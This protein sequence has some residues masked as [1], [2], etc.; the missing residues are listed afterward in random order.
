MIIEN[1]EVYYK[2][3]GVT[4]RYHKGN[5][6]GIS[7]W[8]SPVSS[9]EV[10]EAILLVNHSIELFGLTR[11]LSDV[12]NIKS[13]QSK[14]MQWVIENILPSM[15]SSTLRKFAVLMDIKQ[16]DG[17]EVNHLFHQI[18][19]V[20]HNVQIHTFYDLEEALTWLLEEPTQ[21]QA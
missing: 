18:P 8:K 2:S 4:I 16:K 19:D 17:P 9:H 1:S 20:E 10:R 13:F 7:I 5:E 11:W 6:M 14:D 21:A 3:T 12:R 15:L